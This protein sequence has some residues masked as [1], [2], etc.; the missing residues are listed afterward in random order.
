MRLPFRRF[1][2]NTTCSFDHFPDILIVTWSMMVVMRPPPSRH[3]S[4]ILPRIR[5]MQHR[6]IFCI[7]FRKLSIFAILTSHHCSFDRINYACAPPGCG[8]QRVCLWLIP[9]QPPPHHVWSW[10]CL[11]G[12]GCH[13]GLSRDLM[14]AIRDYCGGT[15]RLTKCIG[16][17]SGLFIPFLQS[18]SFNAKYGIKRTGHLQ[19]IMAR[20][21]SRPSWWVSD[22]SSLRCNRDFK[23]FRLI[24]LFSCFGHGVRCLWFHQILRKPVKTIKRWWRW[25]DE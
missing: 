10:P 24:S 6:T 5:F 15:R 2:R 7:L 20:L 3:K 16:N 4:R 11:R 14:R 12:P 13:R 17:Y 8:I 21:P 9:C 25:E 22:K 18:F 23:E 19:T 1:L